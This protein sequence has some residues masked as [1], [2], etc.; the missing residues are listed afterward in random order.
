MLCAVSAN[1]GPYFRLLD[2][3]H[4]TP[5]VGALID[6][7][8]LDQTE[9]AS[10]LPIITHSPKDGCALPSIVCEDWS[11]LAIGA[12]MNA[13]KIT[14]NIAPLFNVLP[15]VQAAASAVVPDSWTSVHKI[16]AS[17]PDQSVTFSAGPVWQYRQIGNK[18][19]FKIFTGLAL[20]F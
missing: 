16:I 15:W 19:Y 18:G 9:A 12:S 7:L 4:P 8:N 10:L 1:A 13:G 20:H 11:P 6:P 14:L 5:V 3:S 2:P 17:N